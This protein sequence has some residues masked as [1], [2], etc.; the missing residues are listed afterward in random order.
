MAP[1]SDPAE[2]LGGLKV[3]TV[4]E[5]CVLSFSNPTVLKAALDI[6]LLGRGLDCAWHRMLEL[7]PALPPLRILGRRKEAQE[8]GSS[9][10]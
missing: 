3:K 1:T 8:A 10:S 7:M 6:V 4:R 5:L 9:S 2:E